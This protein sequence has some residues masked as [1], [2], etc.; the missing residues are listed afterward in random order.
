MS[1]HGIGIP[2]E[3]VTFLVCAGVVVPLFHRLRL[4]PVLGFLLA[5]LA[6]GPA[7]LARLS[8]PGGFADWIVIRDVEEVRGIAEFGVAFLLFVIGLELSPVRL[9]SMRRLVL[10]L[11]GAQVLVTG[12]V[13]GG[14]AMLFGNPPA[15]AFVIGACLA[16]SST[17]MVLQLLTEQ[18]RIGS[19]AGRA[20]FAVLLLQD[21]A[22]VP[23]LFVVTVL[24]SH[25]GE[26]ATTSL[27]IAFAKAIAAVAVVMLAGRLLLGRFFTLVGGT[28]SPE[29]FVAATLLVVLGTAAGTHAAG[30]SLALGA[31][32]AGMVLAETEFRH[33]V[34]T[35]IEP[36]KGL[37]LGLFFMSVGMGLDPA[38]MG[39]A[40][41]WL[42][43]SILGL[44][45]IK[46]AIFF[47]LARLFGLSAGAAGEAALLFGP[48]GEFAFVVI[49]LAARGGLLEE[50]V[51]QF[52]LTVAGV[53]MFATP[54]AAFAGRQAGRWLGRQGDAR[55]QEREA[56]GIPK[57]EGHY[58]LAGFGRVGRLLREVLQSESLT[59]IAVDSDMTA[60]SRA[61][62]EGIEIFYGDAARID[63]LKKLG[64]DHAQA[65]IVTMDDHPAIERIV[66][67]VRSEWPHI[68]V[69]ARARD[70]AHA[71]ALLD[72]G[73]SGVVPE[74][75]EASLEL[76]ELALRGGGYP[77]DAARHIVHRR[78]L[79]ALDE[80]GAGAPRDSGRRP[81]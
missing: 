15:A 9:W 51:A 13:L 23:I 3:L 11:G 63:F 47:G 45:A 66:K 27:F 58:V 6:V 17:A 44:I 48:A 1:D 57:L 73:A 74:A 7:G 8:E 77:D 16:L 49:G 61:R 46:A 60:V 30:L 54:L 18:G 59:C 71:R 67:A 81:G 24:G 33:E 39:R 4:S 40:A 14:L 28:R 42:I 65:L 35:V 80:L 12:A 53:S 10:G 37:L 36:F 25:G 26:D 29:L 38:A 21:I 78:R 62:M 55:R 31:F 76:A 50:P 68:P 2:H 52:M 64:L 34:A 5:G 70:Q 32:L 22:V 69:F 20:S 72:T 79:L 75:L 41:W 19:E 43:P 56:E